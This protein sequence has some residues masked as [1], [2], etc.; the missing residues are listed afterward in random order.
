[1]KKPEINGEYFIRLPDVWEGY[2]SYIKN[3]RKGIS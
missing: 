3:R 2:D 1:M